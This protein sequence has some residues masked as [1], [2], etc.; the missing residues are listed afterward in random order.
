[1]ELR[2]LRSLVTLSELGS[3]TKCAEKLNLSAAAVHKQL[4]VLEA[5][6]ETPL[7]EKVANRLR[8][9]Q[10]GETLLPHVKRLLAEYDTALS[11]LD[12]WKG[13]RRASVRIGTGPTMSSYVL[14]PMLREFRRRFPEVELYVETGHSLQ[15]LKSLDD[16]SIDLALT[17]SSNPLEEP[18]LAVEGCWKFEIV[19]VAGRKGFPRRCRLADLKS[20]P[21]ILYR[22][23]SRFEVLVDRYF[24]EAG[25]APRVIMRFDNPEAIKAMLR[26]GFGISMLPTWIVSSELKKKTL[27]QIHQKERL[28][29][30]DITLVTRRG[31]YAPRAVGAFIDLLHGW[32][33]KNGH[34]AS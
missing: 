34:V 8:L 20:Y 7:Y 3:I 9:T 26:L 33:W 13:L 12:E 5:E 16:G 6:L 31:G 10:A 23:G 1:V 11:A 25:F 28:L 18:R 2:G 27:F 32:P 30:A 15:L 4:K 21:F 17:V 22:R 24:G 14:P 19:L 29:M